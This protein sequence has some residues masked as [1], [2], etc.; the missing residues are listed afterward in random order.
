[1]ARVAENEQEAFNLFERTESQGFIQWK[2]TDVCMDF[3]CECGCANHYDG[4]FAYVVKCAG[5][6]SLF[7]PSCYVEMIKIEK[8]DFFIDVSYS[9]APENPENI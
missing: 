4:T 1:M 3:H 7:A 5:C 8:A 6:E 2:N 9:I